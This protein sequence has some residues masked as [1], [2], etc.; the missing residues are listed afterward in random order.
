MKCKLQLKIIP[1]VAKLLGVFQPS[2]W[3]SVLLKNAKSTLP[4][5]KVTADL[6]PKV[7]IAYMLTSDQKHKQLSPY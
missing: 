6:H 4:R 2:V 3:N 1:A 5:M 7:K